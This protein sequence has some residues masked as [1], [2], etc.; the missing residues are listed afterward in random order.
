MHTVTVEKDGMHTVTVEVRIPDDLRERFDVRVRQHGGDEG[1]YLQ[2]VLERDLRAEAPQ[3]D[4][5]LREL[6]SLAS[7]PSPADH[8]S[9]EGLVEFAEA[10]VKALRAE[11]RSGARRAG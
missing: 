6:L 5:T 3:P 9:E 1:R 8:L 11:K 10:E 7:G 4:M 2:E